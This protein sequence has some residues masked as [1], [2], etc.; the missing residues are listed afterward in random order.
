MDILL[1]FN[2]DIRG[3]TNVFCKKTVSE[4]IKNQC[5]YTNNNV[6]ERS[7]VETYETKGLFG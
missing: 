1:D 5:A 4:Y 3:E 7:L 2:P 6:C